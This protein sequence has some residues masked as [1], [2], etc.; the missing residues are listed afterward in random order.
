MDYNGPYI[1][2]LS[3]VFL[4][5]VMTSSP[6]AKSSCSNIKIWQIFIPLLTIALR[7]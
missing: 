5:T 3:E 2:K 6:N 1:L 4:P 7:L